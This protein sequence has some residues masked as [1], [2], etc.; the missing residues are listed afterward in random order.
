MKRS[1][2]TLVLAATAVGAFAQA[3][4]TI[5]RPVDNSRVREKVK[6]LFPKGS[7]PP[8]AYVGIFLDGQLIDAV[9]PP[10]Q[11]KYQQYILDT[12]GRGLEDTPPG[13]PAR[14]E[15]KLY[16][17]Y[18]DQPRIVRTS[19]VDLSIANT[20][21]IHVP[22]SGFR[23]RYRFEPG[24][25]L[26]Y[27]MTQRVAV[28]TISESQNKLG[29][30][31][32]ELPIDSETIRM[33]YAV[34]NAYGNGDGLVRMQAMP[35]Q[36]K[37]YAILTTSDATEPRKFTQDEMAAIYMR[38]TPTGKEIFGS[39]PAYWE[40]EGTASQG[41]TTNLWAAFPL[42]SL[43]E[44]AVRPGDSWPTKFQNGKIDLGKLYGQT[45]VIKTVGPARGEF[46]GVEWEMG[47][48]CAKIRNTISEAQMSDEDKKLVKSGA[49]MAGEKLKLDETVWFALDTRQVLK[50]IR[51]TTVETKQE[52]MGA[53]SPFGGGGVPG[54]PS[55]APGMPGGPGMPPGGKNRPGGRGVGNTAPATGGITINVQRPGAGGRPGG[56]PGAP[57]G[58]PGGP[59]RPGGY[60]GGP[61]GGY[62]GQ[63]GYPGMGGRTG[64][65]GTEN[66]ND[67]TYI[68]VRI[69]RIFVLES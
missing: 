14:L 69:Q 64:M 17:N 20:A 65:G 7:I 31:P 33:K 9:V 28:D 43:P 56:F 62:P 25:E 60:P 35:Q 10:V 57:G 48:P 67:A 23:L 11:G 38:L 12:K 52:G 24:T 55:G 46:V 3:N 18:N 37:D 1:I 54:G 19:S 50:V 5:V 49:A 2:G 58:Y 26:V 15:A 63:G 16:V 68:R 21:S 45:S 8:G 39:I 42:P 22:N 32:A 6:I 30:K 4:F 44:K 34:D 66:A 47:H 27:R 36:G 53:G 59:G 51:D 40:L 29:G 41:V 61:G 13:K